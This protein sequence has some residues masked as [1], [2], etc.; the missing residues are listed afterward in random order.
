MHPLLRWNKIR[1][2]LIVTPAKAG[3]QAL[4]KLD[5]RVRGNDDPCVIERLVF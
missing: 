3:V 1:L 4:E 5:S 2:H